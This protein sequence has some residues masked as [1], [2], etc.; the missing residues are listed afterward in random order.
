MRGN[1][2]SP[3][4]LCLLLI[5]SVAVAREGMAQSKPKGEAKLHVTVLDP[6]GSAIV[7]AQLK[8]SVGGEP[9]QAGQT[10][11]QGQLLLLP[12][13]P[14]TYHLH[15]EAPGFEPKD[16]DDVQLTDGH[17]QIDIQLEVVNIKEQVDVTVNRREDATDPRG[18]SFST[19]MTVEHIAQLPDDPEELE[20]TLRQMAGPGAVIRVNG[21]RGGKLPPKSQIREIRFRRNSYAAEN[22]EAGLVSVDIY[23]KPG[24]SNW[25]GT[26]STSFRDEALAARN[27]F[28]PMRGAEQYRRFGLDLEGPLWRNR[29]SLFLSADG[30]VFYDTK[31]VVAAL[32]D[33][34]FND[35]IQRP[36]RTLTTSARIE[37]ALT[38]TH[39]LRMSLQRFARRE[40]NLGAGDFD[41]PERGFSTDLSET[42]LRVSDSGPINSRLLNE[43]R[44]QAR[45]Q[46]MESRPVSHLPSIQVLNAFNRGGAQMENTRNTSGVEFENNIDFSFGNHLMRAGILFQAEKYHSVDLQNA[47]GTF[48][49]ASLDDY[50]AQR[51][52]TYTQRVGESAVEFTQYRFGWFVQDDIRLRKN[53]TLSLGLRHEVQSQ[54]GDRANFAPRAGMS[55]SPF[56]DGKT[57]F[58][59][60][61]GIFYDWFGANVYEQTLRVDGQQQRDIV[62]LNP[63]FPNPFSGG[64]QLAL[65]PSRYQQD[66]N[67]KMPYIGQASFAVERQLPKQFQ[68]IGTYLYQ[69]GVHLLRSRNI[70]AP[71]PGVG[72]PFPDAGN[73]IQFESTA[74]SSFNILNA[75]V[76]RISSRYQ[77]F[78]TYSYVRATND[79]DG[80]F[81][82]PADNYNLR[83]ERGPSAL[84]VRHSLLVLV[85]VRLPKNLRLGTF[86][87][88]D[89]PLPYNITTGFDDNGDSI[90]NDRPLGVGRNSA[91]GA[92]RWDL[93]S[94]LSWSFGFG[95]RGG[96]GDSSQNPR[97]VTISAQTSADVLGSFA[98]P[99]TSE[100]RWRGE[101]YVQAF[102]LFN[103][104]NP[105]NYT[106]VQSSPFFGHATSALPGRRIE[107][108]LRFSF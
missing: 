65:P 5:F 42:L 64:L 89:S 44:F 61:A 15:V 18:D 58:R 98:P 7:G 108:G 23:T 70:N 49:F 67:M 56:A 48:T 51:P 100:S 30:S 39:T 80:P 104:A 8:L 82:L 90:Q 66:P 12:V 19:V 60:G 88:D 71:I 81:S 85:N 6:S 93:S 43:F 77:I 29:T 79:A 59:A 91:R 72:R 69:G 27:A 2:I 13:A 55:W 105:V 16:L 78:A 4:W 68:F 53:L 22:H 1:R 33:G 24:I 36:S 106:G 57:T 87:F 28:A 73:I 52:T 62:V 96:G 107:T 46:N 86:F 94:R 3:V 74:N 40:D 25:H 9:K 95:K 97:P 101:L 34:I 38:N 41:L 32:P 21:F 99:G 31:T 83:A 92:P 103:H 76:T 14:G 17:N 63:G 45:W 11:Q 37:H 50:R 47:N 54:L 10:N 20:A 26:F 75:T 35:V 84:D 102:N